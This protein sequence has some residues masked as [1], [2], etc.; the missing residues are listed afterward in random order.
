MRFFKTSPGKFALALKTV[1]LFKWNRNGA[2]AASTHRT[3]EHISQS[4]EM[5]DWV[6]D[7]GKTLN[8]AFDSCID[9]LTEKMVADIQFDNR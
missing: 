8:L 9:G 1:M 2:Q 7:D 5:K 3:Y 4:L 6:Q